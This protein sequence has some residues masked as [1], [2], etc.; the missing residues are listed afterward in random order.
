MSQSL[1]LPIVVRGQASKL[2]ITEHLEDQ[3]LAAFEFHGGFSVF[4]GLENKFRRINSAVMLVQDVIC[5]K[6]LTEKSKA[7][8]D[9]TL[10]DLKA[11]T[12]SPDGPILAGTRARLREV[13]ARLG[14]HRPVDRPILF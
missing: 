10:K 7:S 6:L 9:D 5:P 11:R 2:R 14:V 1:P 8:L 13:A 3:A 12:W 4:V